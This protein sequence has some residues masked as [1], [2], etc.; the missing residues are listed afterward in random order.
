MLEMFRGEKLRKPDVENFTRLLR[1]FQEEIKQDS[2]LR[3]EF[4]QF[5]FNKKYPKGSVQR[6]IR[7]WKVEKYVMGSDGYVRPR[8]VKEVKKCA[9]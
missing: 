1:E 2:Y 4:N 9:A 7:E 6:N 8:L 5:M 3:S